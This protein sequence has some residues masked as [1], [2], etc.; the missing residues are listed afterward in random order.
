MPKDLRFITSF[1]KVDES[2]LI[3]PIGS[4]EQH[5]GMPVGTDCIIAEKLSWLV[6]EKYEKELKREKC[7]IAPALCYAFS[8]EWSLSSGTV[9][10]SIETFSKLI[11][12]IIKGFSNWGFR[13]I[14]FLNAHGGN[15]A[16]LASILTE[17][18]NS[19]EKYIKVGLLDYWKCLDLDIG[20]A[21]NVE[22][23]ILRFLGEDISQVNN[24]NCFKA[25]TSS[26]KG[27]KI[28]TRGSAYPEIM[29]PKKEKKVE[30]S[31]IIECLTKAITY[32]DNKVLSSN[33]YI[34]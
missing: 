5:C 11:K 6:C 32:F 33:H 29:S 3:I 19:T 25:K 2:I 30:L 16:I 9:T 8:P 18:V 23:L 34:G 15:S 31:K 12:E 10:L 21:S 14:L 1:D 22:Y 26:Y 28:F 7:I 20:H 17:V 13:K 4:I 27:L 24:K